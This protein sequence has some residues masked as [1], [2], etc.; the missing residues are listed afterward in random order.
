MFRGDNLILQYIGGPLLECRSV[1]FYAKMV[2]PI[3]TTL[4]VRSSCVQC[5][6]QARLSLRPC[7]PC[8]RSGFPRLRG[9][10]L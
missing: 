6:P 9:P 5:L 10:K 7:N 8:C 4:H 1:N 2:K 3:A